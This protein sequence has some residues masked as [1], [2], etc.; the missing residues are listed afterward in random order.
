[1]PQLPAGGVLL[2]HGRGA[3]PGN[4]IKHPLELALELQRLCG[5][6]G[7]RIDGGVL[8]ALRWDHN[9]NEVIV[10]RFAVTLLDS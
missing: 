10:D 7:Y 4:P 8:L 5:A 3:L 6:E 9:G 1:L 2:N